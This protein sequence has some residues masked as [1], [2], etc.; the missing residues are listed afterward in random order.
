MRRIMHFFT[1]SKES[2]SESK[3]KSDKARLLTTD[4]LAAQSISIMEPLTYHGDPRVGARVQVED[5]LVDTSQHFG[6]RK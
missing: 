3:A 2:T 6:R 1:G 4:A 5:P